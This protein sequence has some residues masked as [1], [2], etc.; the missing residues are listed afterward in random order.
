MRRRR[1]NTAYFYF[2]HSKFGSYI[3]S[4][5]NYR[6]RKLDHNSICY[7][8]NSKK[9]NYLLYQK[10]RLDP[11]W[12]FEVIEVCECRDDYERKWHERFWTDLL[13]PE[14]NSIS[15]INEDYEKFTC[16]CGST[17][18]LRHRTEHLRTQTH[19]YYVKL[20]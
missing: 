2:I 4:T 8:E 7:N 14:L 3:G 16:K 17:Y 1:N 9:Y 15:P 12:Y 19:R 5:W 6:K 18:N 10:L 20:H 11:D 13:Q